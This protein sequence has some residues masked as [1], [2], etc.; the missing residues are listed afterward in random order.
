MMSVTLYTT[1][2][3]AVS[4]VSAAAVGSRD[5][6]LA[7]Y[8]QCGGQN[9]TGSTVCAAP[10]VC[11][12]QSQWFVACGLLRR[13][14]SHPHSSFQVLSVFGVDRVS[15]AGRNLDCH[16]AGNEPSSRYVV[17]ACAHFDRRQDV[18]GHCCAV[19]YAHR[20]RWVSAFPHGREHGR[21][22]LVGLSAFCGER[23]L[24]Y[25]TRSG[26]DTNGYSGSPVAPPTAQFAH[27]ASEGVNIFVGDLPCTI[28]LS[29]IL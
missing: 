18:N 25:F 21:F 28:T 8:A 15:H 17:E 16:P 10:A 20:Q 5:A 12:A 29:Y 19:V 9:W 22:R 24:K 27:F 14:C 23:L 4:L 13:L 3:M 7:M 2:L 11:V 26:M 6:G 1:V